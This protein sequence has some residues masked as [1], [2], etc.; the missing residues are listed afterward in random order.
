MKKISFLFVLLSVFINSY[1]EDGLV[2]DNTQIVSGESAYI[3]VKMDFAENH[4]YV[5]YQ[6]KVEL[7]SGISLVKVEETS[8]QASFVLPSNQPTNIFKITDFPISNGILKVASNPSTVIGAHEGVLVYIPVKATGS[9]LTSGDVLNGKLSGVTFT[10]ANA[11]AEYFD[12]VD[13][14]ITIADQVVLDENSEIAPL[15][16]S[17]NVNVKVQRNIKANKWSTIC[18]PFEMTEAQAKVAFG[19]D[20][21]LAYFDS[22]NVE[23]TGN[24]VTG[25]TIQFEKDDLSGGFAANYPYLIK[26]SKD[27]T[28]FSVTATINPSDEIQATYS[29]GSGANKRKGEFIGTYLANTEVPANGLFIYNDKFYY[30]NGSTKMKAFRGYFRLDHVINVNNGARIGL[31]IDDEATGINMVHGSGVKADSYYDLQGRKIENPKKGL[32]INNGKKVVVK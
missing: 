23:K 21:K 15:A 14:T 26:V 27:I 9:G 20:V 5:S 16:T 4:D 11:S 3:V 25:I 2:V 32:Y 13:F 18:L 24:D 22:Y 10:H 6:F 19:N 12:D 30:S 8:G 29:K 31:S 28:E 1:G 17:G 7:P